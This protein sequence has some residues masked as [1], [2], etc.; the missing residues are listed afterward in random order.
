MNEILNKF[1]LA[2]PKL[3]PEMYLSTFTC[4]FIFFDH[5]LK[6]NKEYKN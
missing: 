5:L 6:A 1:S 2:E 3:M 4:I